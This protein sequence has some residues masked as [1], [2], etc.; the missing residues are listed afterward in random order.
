[1]KHIFLV[2]LL[3]ASLVPLQAADTNSAQPFGA[4]FPNLDSLTTDRWWTKGIAAPDKPNAQPPPPPMDVPRDQVVAFALY[5]V[6]GGV[7]KMTA[8]LPAE[9]G[10]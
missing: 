8:Q 7:M 6:H 5:T 9:A 1:M 10:G 4:D 3:L 2:N